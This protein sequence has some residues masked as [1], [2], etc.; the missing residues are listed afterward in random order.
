MSKNKVPVDRAT[1]RVGEKMS[2]PE[3]M[4]TQG[5]A[6]AGRV[7]ASTNIGSAS[8]VKTTATAWN[9]SLVLLQINNTNKSKA[10]ADLDTAI[11]NEPSLVRDCNL[12]KRQM[13]AAID[14]FS[15][16]SKD[17]VKSFNVEV[18]ARQTRPEATVP[19]NVRPMKVN[20]PTY[21][22]VRWNPTIGAQGYMLQHATNTADASTYAAPIRVTQARYHLG[23]QTA[24][25]TVY[26]RVAALDTAVPGGQ[27]AFSAWVAVV[28]TA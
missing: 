25:T 17:M 26:F 1:A 19:V 4:V 28:V 24:G 8:D 18:E 20:R 9:A 14:V 10:R 21:A 12:N 11:S 16:G 7:M 15:K 6:A 5:M 13:L 23:G 2:T 22:S 3:E 27:T